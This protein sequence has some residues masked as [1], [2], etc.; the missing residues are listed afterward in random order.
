MSVKKEIKEQLKNLANDVRT[1]KITHKELQRSN[2]KT[3]GVDKMD[4]K[5]L[6]TLHRGEYKALYKKES[7]KDEFRFKHIARCLLMGR[8]YKQ[9]EKKCRFD[10][11]PDDQDVNRYIQEFCAM[12][13][14]D[15]YPSYA[16]Q[17]VNDGT[18]WDLEHVETKKVHPN[19]K[20]KFFEERRDKLIAE[21]AKEQE[22]EEA[23]E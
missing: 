15:E 8:S 22:L 12:L 10:N 7:L 5:E 3:V 23:G 2:S 19:L 18:A 21:V 4:W 6:S 13:N 17:L 11:A 1:A 14:L 9:L 16:R 20:I